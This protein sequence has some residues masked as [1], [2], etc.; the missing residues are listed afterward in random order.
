L[1]PFLQHSVVDRRSSLRHSLRA[2]LRVRVWKSA[3]PEHG[4]E[5]ENVSQ[6]GIFFATDLSLLTG[7]V[8]E[9]LLTMP[10]ELTGEPPRQWCCTGHVV[11]VESAGSPEHRSGVGVKFHCYEIAD[12]EAS[13]PTQTSSYPGILGSE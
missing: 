4:G 9:V 12:L 5:C 6:Q 7:T 13:Q 1:R 3:I 8:V 2:P 11:R 10:E